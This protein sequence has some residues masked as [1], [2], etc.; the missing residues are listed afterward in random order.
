MTLGTVTFTGREIPAKLS[1]LGG[2]QDIIKTKF[3]GGQISAQYLGSFPHDKEWKG[4]LFGA[5]AQSRAAQL[6][7]LWQSGQTVRLAHAQWSYLGMVEDFEI[8][9]EQYNYIFYKCKFMVFQDNSQGS[10]QTSTPTPPETVLSQSQGNMNNIVGNPPAPYSFSAPVQ[11]NVT[12]LN[13]ALNSGLSQAG[14]SISNMPAATITNLQQQ[15]G[16]I[17]NQIAPVMSGTDPNAASAAAQ[18]NNSLTNINNSLSGSAPIIGQEQ[19][20]NPNLFQLASKHYGDA[21]LFK[22]IRD[23][24]GLNN[25]M[26]IG[27]YNLDIPAAPTTSQPNLIWQIS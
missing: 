27:D 7:Q 22:L 5:S 17:Q 26:P 20:T 18:L 11:Q 8:E 10:N 14:G 15:V 24:N 12:N 19:I 23:A 21:G 25:S 13:N 2:H 1:S 16:T 3:D 9:Q 6:N 4:E